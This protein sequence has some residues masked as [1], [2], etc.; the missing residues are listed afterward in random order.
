[1]GIRANAAQAASGIVRWGLRHIAHRPAANLPG[2]VGLAIDPHLIADLRDRMRAGSIVVVGT[3]GKTTVTNLVADVLERAGMSVACNRTGANLKSGVAAT[4]LHSRGADWGVFEC[5]ELWSAKV[6]P[7]LQPTYMVLLNLFRDQLDRCGEIDRIQ[8]AIVSGL[9]ASPETVLIYN[10]DDPLCT[11]VARRVAQERGADR[12]VTFGVA[13]SMGLVQ[14]N[15]ADAT[16]CQACSHMLEYAFRQYGQLGS[17]ACPACDFARPDLAFQAQDVTLHARGLDLRIRWDDGGVPSTA[18]LS[19]SLSGSYMAYNLLA[20]FAAATLCGCTPAQVQSAVRA[21]D[22]KNGRLQEYRLDGRRVL[23]NLAKNPTGFNQ[24]LRIVGTDEGPRVVAFFINDRE[25]DGRDVSWIW[26]IDFEELL[27]QPN[28]QAVFAGGERRH[29]L[30]VRLKYAGVSAELVDGVEEVFARAGEIPGVSADAAVYAIANYTALPPVHAALDRM[31]ARADAEEAE[32]DGVGAGAGAGG[33]AGIMDADG[34]AAGN[35]ARRGGA[36]GVPAAGAEAPV[37]A[38]GDAP[39]SATD[40]PSVQIVHMLPDLLNLYGDGG[41]VRILAKRLAWR[42]IPVSIREVRYGDDARLDEADLV[43][44]GGSPDREQRLASEQLSVMRDELAAYVDAG[45]PVLAV[46]GGYQMLGRT[47]LLD[48]E[49]VPGLALLPMETHRP[50][51]SSDRLVDDIALA[52]SL[53]QMPVIGY[54][55]HAGRTVLD[56]DAV[57][58]GRV[59]SHTGCGNADSCARGQA[60]DGIVFRNV[61]G[62]YLHGPLLAK[63]P[64]VA[65]WL[66]ARALERW[67]MRVG[68]TAPELT[69]LDDAEEHAANAFMARR[70]IR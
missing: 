18:G 37:A 59:V 41:N 34:Q 60:A 25:G 13:D 6:L 29:D 31:V 66:L 12:S 50:G 20:V 24:N 5:D 45:A 55:N 68:R 53:A 36:D 10:A 4:L 8:D 21:F 33:C 70:I 27:S 32:C 44:I 56:A 43:F 62:T 42:G 51:T 23:L 3:N 39:E 14:N 54:E 7:D 65:D 38:G 11:W 49:E 47:W 17:Y 58:F 67:A 16:I 35:G 30:R 9:V 19:A 48:G 26:D 2:S 63:S 61:L 15:V 40:V 46:C 64:E 69:P 28:I 52:S 1:M 22:P 57:P